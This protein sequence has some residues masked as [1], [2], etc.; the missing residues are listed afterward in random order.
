VGIV[1]HNRNPK[2]WEAEAKESG[3]GGQHGLYGEFQASMGHIARI[4]Q[5]KSVK[6]DWLWVC[7]QQKTY[8]SLGNVKSLLYACIGNSIL[9]WNNP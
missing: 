5:K 1:V 4:W 3:V 2:T 8:P 9:T 7:E 6:M